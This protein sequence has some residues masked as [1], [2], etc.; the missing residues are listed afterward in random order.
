VTQTPEALN[1]SVAPAEPPPIPVQ[2][3]TSQPQAPDAQLPRHEGLTWPEP[4][5]GA[6]TVP[7][8][9]PPGEPLAAAPWPSFGAATVPET[10]SPWLPVQPAASR[11]RYGWPW[12]VLAVVAAVA[13]LA[14]ASAI[15]LGDR[16][17]TVGLSD[18]ETVLEEDFSSGPGKFTEFDQDGAVGVHRAGA[19]ELTNQA[20]AGVYQSA[21]TISRAT[22]VDVSARLELVSG[23]HPDAGVGVSVEPNMTETYLFG[24]AGNGNVFLAKTGLPQMMSTRPREN[25]R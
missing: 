14:G 7:S 13:L 19:Y 24:L 23:R 5:G 6:P 16:G 4:P 22:A 15:L 2:D 18:A 17:D 12:V 3:V 10:P 21:V 9:R 8:P 11:S 1:S 20:E 25:G